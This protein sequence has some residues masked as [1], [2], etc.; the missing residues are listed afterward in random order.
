MTFRTG[1]LLTGQMYLLIK[2]PRGP[3]T[4]EGRFAPAGTPITWDS[5][6]HVERF[7]EQYGVEYTGTNAGH[8]DSYGGRFLYWIDLPEYGE[9]IGAELGVDFEWTD[10]AS[11][12]VPTDWSPE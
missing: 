5:E 8:E 9:G 7:R 11:A 10:E 2:N 3:G 12:S 4:D 1:R 6:K